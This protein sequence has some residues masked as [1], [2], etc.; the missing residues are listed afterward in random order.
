MENKS[1]A[2]YARRRFIKN[3]AK[4]AGISIIST[5]F[6]TDAIAAKL[7]KAS[8]HYQ[9]NLTGKPDCDDCAYYI[10]PKSSKSPAAC[11]LVEGQINPHGWCES[12]SARA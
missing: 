3:T 10:A 7:S 12:F 6:I 5:V 11:K 8:V 4:L 2:E 1:N 9:A